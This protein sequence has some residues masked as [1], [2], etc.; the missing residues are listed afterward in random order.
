[1][2]GLCVAPV[3]YWHASRAAEARLGDILPGYDRAMEREMQI[4]M[5]P[6]GLV[7]MQ[8]SNALQEPGTQA[9][10]IAAGAAIIARGC[11]YAA[12]RVREDEEH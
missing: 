11:Y 6:L 4:Q 2:S 1:M 8:W 7:L 12:A 3:Y 10:L 9:L 5:G